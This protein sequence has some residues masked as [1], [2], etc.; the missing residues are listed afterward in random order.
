M[1]YLLF[2]FSFIAYLGLRLAKTYYDYFEI[3]YVSKKKIVKPEFKFLRVAKVLLLSLFSKG[4]IDWKINHKKEHKWGY[5]IIK[6]LSEF[7]AIF[8]I[9]SLIFSVLQYWIDSSTNVELAKATVLQ[10]EQAQHQIKDFLKI[11]KLG[12]N[13]KALVVFLLIFCASFFSLFEKYKLKNKFLKFNKILKTLLLFFTISTSFT[14]F[15]NRITSIENSR[16]GKLDSH[17]LQIIENNKLLIQE[18]HDE[19]TQTVINE[20]LSNEEIFAVLEKTNELKSITESITENEQYQYFIT[21]AP[22]AIVNNLAV[23]SFTQNYS[24]KT[25]FQKELTYNINR[26]N[27]SQKN[28]STSAECNFYDD[29]KRKNNKWTESN[30]TESY[31]HTAKVKFKNATRTNKSRYSKYY[32]KYKEPIDILLKNG[33]GN[34]GKKWING[35]LEFL[36]DDIPFLDKFIDPIIHD[37]IEDFITKKTEIIF[38]NTFTGT[39]ESIKQEINTCAQ[40]FSSSFSQ[41]TKNNRKLQTLNSELTSDIKNIEHIPSRTF[42]KINSYNRAVDNYLNALSSNNRWE[43]IRKNFR[44]RINY[45]NLGFE[46]NQIENFKTVIDDWEDL[47]HKNKFKW[48]NEK[49]NNLEEQFY[50]YTKDDGNAKAA[51]GFILQQQDWDGAVDY[52]TYIAPDATARGNPYY[53][54]K[55]YYNSTGK[56][57]QF[58]NLYDYKTDEGVAKLCPH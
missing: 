16:V 21:I 8:A 22:K 3:D 52:Y 15:G 31:T 54:L 14:F 39:E 6:G 27:S 46:S 40:E 41:Q 9:T 11:F 43:G 1:I 19:V 47:K 34:T 7:F 13:Y 55:Y 4:K 37:P 26:Y 24:S 42:S 5:G 28:T 56:G 48:Y 20:I 49:L 32:Y 30:H 35:L 44:R 50:L 36:K 25:N 51:W 33:Y 2:T 38:K 57:N 53:L 23:N 10:I 12:A 18:I 29:F 58:E 45:D 17:K